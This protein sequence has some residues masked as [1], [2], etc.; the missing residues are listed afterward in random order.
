MDRVSLRRRLSL[1]ITTAID[2]S[3]A[4]AG[5]TFAQACE[6]ET[7]SIEFLDWTQRFDRFIFTGIPSFRNVDP[8][9]QQRFINLVDILCDSDTPSY[10]TSE[11]DYR[12]FSVDAEEPPDAFRMLSGLQLL[13]GADS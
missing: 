1:D 7:S 8:A 9:G 2:R 11:L 6:A 10:L 3:A 12:E 4:E 5:C 13:Q